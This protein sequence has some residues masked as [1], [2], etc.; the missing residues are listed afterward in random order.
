LQKQ[1][2]MTSVSLNILPLSAWVPMHNDRLFIAGP[3][4]IESRQQLFETAEK[5]AA[6]KMV[7]VL[8]GSR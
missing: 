4:S 7:S 2:V 1:H 8:R 3:C 6:G 5:I